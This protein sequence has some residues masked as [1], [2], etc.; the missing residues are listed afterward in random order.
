M[1]RWRRLDENR[2]AGF[3]GIRGTAGQSLASGSPFQTVKRDPM[4]EQEGVPFDA[5]AIIAALAKATG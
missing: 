5:G 3:K 4:R 2:S 1:G